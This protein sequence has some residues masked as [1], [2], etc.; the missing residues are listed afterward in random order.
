MTTGVGSPTLP[1]TPGKAAVSSSTMKAP[2]V[3]MSAW[4]KCAKRMMLK[5]S[6]TPMAPMA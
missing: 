1:P 2:K 6:V 4:A 3:I 5:I